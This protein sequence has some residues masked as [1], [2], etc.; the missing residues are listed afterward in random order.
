MWP[1]FDEWMKL[2]R[3]IAQEKGCPIPE[4]QEEA[5][6]FIWRNQYDNKMSPE[7]AVYYWSVANE[8]GG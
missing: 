5:E 7:E 6:V 8:S 2:C 1:E 4:N 3:K